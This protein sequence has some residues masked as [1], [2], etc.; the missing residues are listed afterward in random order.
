MWPF[1][2]RQSGLRCGGCRGKGNCSRCR[3]RGTTGDREM[4]GDAIILG[5][6]ICKR[7]GGSGACPGCGGCGW[8]GVGDLNNGEK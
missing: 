6:V 2:G 1:K 3:G 8:V 5:P 7:C 4:R